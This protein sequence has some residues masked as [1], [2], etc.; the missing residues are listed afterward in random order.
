M[1][2]P[3]ADGNGKEWTIL[4]SIKF[5]K[6]HAKMSDRAFRVFMAL[7]AYA[8]ENRGCYP[9]N[10]AIGK[11]VDK[12]PEVVGR[13][14]SE[15]VAEGFIG[16]IPKPRG[17]KAR[18]GIAM[19]TRTDPRSPLAISSDPPPTKSSEPSNEIVGQKKD[20]SE[21]DSIKKAA[22]K[23]DQ[24]IPPSGDVKRGVPCSPSPSAAQGAPDSFSSRKRKPQSKKDR[25]TARELDRV[26]REEAANN[27]HGPQ[28]RTP[29]NVFGST[30]Q[31]VEPF[32]PEAPAAVSQAEIDARMILRRQIDRGFRHGKP[33]DLIEAELSNHPD[34]SPEMKQWIRD[35]VARWKGDTA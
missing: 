23:S 11:L 30:T 32:A 1:T 3:S 14:L 17:G 6:D 7:E 2:A 12:H 34:N 26:I 24:C 20:S 15:L 31:A 9:S 33:L 21:K 22:T 4:V 8:R 18:S 10:A 5:L 27:G 19:L 13:I 35:E 29:V 28:G 25:P 16:R